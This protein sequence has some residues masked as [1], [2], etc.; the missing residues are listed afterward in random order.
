M[1]VRAAI[2]LAFPAALALALDR[3]MSWKILLEIE[4]GLAAWCILACMFGF[5]RNVTRL[6]WLR[7]PGFFRRTRSA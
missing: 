7:S 1:A 2:V 5:M 4:P 3:A 6:A